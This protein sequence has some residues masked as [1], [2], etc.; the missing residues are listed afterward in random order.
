MNVEFG[1]IVIRRQ[2]FINV[3]VVLNVKSTLNP[4]MSPTT[5][6]QASA[7]IRRAALNCRKSIL[8]RPDQGVTL[9]PKP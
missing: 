6:S 4:K 5:F 8:R 9:N 2:D 7:T 1:L 3:R